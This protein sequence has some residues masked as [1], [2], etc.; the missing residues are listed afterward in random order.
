M[1]QKTNISDLKGQLHRQLLIK[2]QFDKFSIVLMTM[3][4]IIIQHKTLLIKLFFN[5][6]LTTKD[7]F[8][9][10]RVRLY[11]FKVS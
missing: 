3:Y 7:N 5:L 8:Q 4:N 11:L 1:N 9:G 10:N 6:A 2:L